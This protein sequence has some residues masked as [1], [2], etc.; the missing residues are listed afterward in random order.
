MS[1]EFSKM[2]SFLLIASVA[3]SL[4]LDFCWVTKYTRD[5]KFVIVPKSVTRALSATKGIR[6]VLIMCC[7]LSGSSRPVLLSHLRH[8][9]FR[10]GVKRTVYILHTNFHENLGFHCNSP[11]VKNKLDFRHGNRIF[12]YNIT[13]TGL[14]CIIF[15]MKCHLQLCIMV[16]F[17]LFNR[18]M[19]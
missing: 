19:L 6:F 1:K 10:L 15:V 12:L 11:L 17:K 9:C 18:L 16:K 4:S 14:L 2:K 7:E 3:E 8:L 5:N 13:I